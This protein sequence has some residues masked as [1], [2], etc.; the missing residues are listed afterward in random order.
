MVAMVL[1]AATG[2]Q[3]FD[4]NRKG[5]IIGLGGGLGFTSYQHEEDWGWVYETQMDTGDRKTTVAFATDFRI[6]GG[7]N[8]QFMLYYENR[9]AWLSA[10][11]DSAG[12]SD[13]IAAHA[14]GLIGFSYYLKPITPTWYL[15]G[16]V[17]TS[18][19]MEPFETDGDTKSGFGLSGGAGYEF[20]R[21]VSVEGTVNWGDTEKDECKTKAMSVLFTICYIWY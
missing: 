6:G 15:V 18:S 8:E 14:V 16:S 17:G 5:F 1:T 19:W 21:R 13:V 20:A 11:G 10:E 9:V 12:G 3:A 7:F 4:R 2:V